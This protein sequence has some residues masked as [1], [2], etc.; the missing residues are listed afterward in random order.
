MALT[1]LYRV[2]PELGLN[3][4]NGLGKELQLLQRKIKTINDCPLHVKL[5]LIGSLVCVG[6]AMTQ[7]LFGTFWLLSLRM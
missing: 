2:R 7:P 1:R 3:V 6:E 5:T 4:A